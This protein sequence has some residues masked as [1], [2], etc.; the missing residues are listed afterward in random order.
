MK[1]SKADLIKLI[2]EANNQGYNLAVKHADRNYDEF[3]ADFREAI[4]C[5]QDETQ[6][7]KRAMP[8]A[9]ASAKSQ[10]YEAGYA[11]G[12]E[13]G[14]ALSLNHEEAYNSGYAQGLSD[15]KHKESA[16]IR[17][18]MEGARESERQKIEDAQP[19]LSVW[20]R[21][22]GPMPISRQGEVLG[23]PPGIDKVEAIKAIRKAYN[24]HVEGYGLKEVKEL[25]EIESFGA[26]YAAGEPLPQ[27]KAVELY[28]QLQAAG[29]DPVLR[30]QD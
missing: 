27:S 11:Q 25:V 23:Y 30:A 16:R 26:R 12:L 9:L 29:F 6:E 15:G 3:S 10:A 7:V 21:P 17:E 1:I 20:F 8:E 24:S 2:V 18:L 4:K 5:A 19:K 13:E 22:C 28:L 14:K